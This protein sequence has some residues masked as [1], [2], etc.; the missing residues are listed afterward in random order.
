M[1]F[2][3]IPQQPLVTFL[4]KKVYEIY[5]QLPCNMYE[6]NLCCH[7]YSWLNDKIIHLTRSKTSEIFF[8]ISQPV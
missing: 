2:P 3:K 1:T 8:L 6:N 4:N 7:I 5:S